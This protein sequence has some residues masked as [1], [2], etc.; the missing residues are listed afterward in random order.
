MT[1][2]IKC[3]MS[4]CVH[5]LEYYI[6]Q[7]SLI[8]K[9]VQFQNYAQYR[10]R[11]TVEEFMGIKRKVLILTVLTLSLIRALPMRAHDLC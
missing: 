4:I 9:V 11:R 3:L 1:Q 8:V 5:T 10:I 2:E 6:L 7:V